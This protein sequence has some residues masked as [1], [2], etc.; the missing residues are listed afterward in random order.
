LLIENGLLDTSVFEVKVNGLPV[1]GMVSDISI[2]GN[3][4][5]I[6][7]TNPEATCTLQMGDRTKQVKVI[8]C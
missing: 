8:K 2:Y 7:T 1:D 5:N 6:A 4:G 3:N